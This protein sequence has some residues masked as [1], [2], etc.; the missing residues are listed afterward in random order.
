MISQHTIQQITNRIDIIDVVGE[1]VKLKK[2][3]TNYIGLCPFHNEK[4]PSFTVSPSKEIYKCFGCGK[5]GNTITFLMEHEKYSYVEALRW[6]AARYHIEVEET[7]TSAEQKQF[8]QTADSLYVINNFAQ[9]F[10]TEQLLHTDNGKAIALSYL[11]ERGF[12]DTVI[13]KFQLG[14]NPDTK[15]TLTKALLANQFNAE[16]LPKTGLVSVRNNNELVDNYRGRIIF[17]IHNISG[18][19]IGF[20]ARIIGKNDHAPKYINTP[21]NELYVKSKI[22]Y[23]SYFAR[24]AIDKADECLL[25]EGYTDVI[26]LHQAGIENVVASGGTSLTTDQL[27]L[28]KKYTNNLTIIYDGDNAG[29]KAALRGLDMALEEGLDVRLVLIPDNEDPDSYVNKVGAKAFNEFV[30]AAKKDFIIFQLEVMLREAGGD[31]TKKSNVVN[32]VAETLSRINRVED[33]TKQQDY[34]RQCAGILRID[35][36]GLTTLVNKYKRERLAKEE[37]QLPFETNRQ[38][39]FESTG[40]QPEHVP[41]EAQLLFLQ[42]EAHERNVLRVLLEYGLRSWDETRAVAEYIF[43]EL[44]QFH[45]E[46]PQLEKLYETYKS[47]YYQGLEPNPKTL[48]YHDDETIRQLVTGIT[49]PPY[50]LSQKW[51]E[52]MEGMNILNRDTAHQ[53]VLMSVNYFKLRKIKKMFEENQRDMETAGFDDF[54]RLLE[55]HKHLK[56]IETELTKKIGTVILK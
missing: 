55:V 28:I 11:R 51:D 10:F 43:E 50:E 24:M 29:V 14:Y 7:E 5:S 22:L 20:G 34:I 27:R 30:A 12:R 33:F 54:K 38:Q 17:P 23:G 35:E 47:Q 49:L 9:K 2:R 40:Q 32:Q 26:S 19:I 41:D 25:V 1:F 15:D 36:N 45:I 39:A 46:T 6:L 31:V 4:G 48:L 8:L 56:A 13:D 18:K 52:V 37:K 53:D 21:E 16:L 3:G 42:D 44:E